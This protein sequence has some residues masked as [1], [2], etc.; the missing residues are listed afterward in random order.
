VVSG[1]DAASGGLLRKRC[2][3]TEVGHLIMEAAVKSNLKRVTLELGRKSPNI[4]FADTD[5]DEA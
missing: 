2:A 1:V 4:A 5:L 3:S